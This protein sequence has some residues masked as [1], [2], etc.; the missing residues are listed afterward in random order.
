[1]P[2]KLAANKSTLVKQG[3]NKAKFVNPSI[4]FLRI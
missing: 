2:I 1:M 4:K 3:K